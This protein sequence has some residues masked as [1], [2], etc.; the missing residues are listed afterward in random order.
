MHCRN[1][2][3]TLVGIYCHSCGQ[4]AADLGRPFY[5]LVQEVLQETLEVDGRVSRTLSALVLKPGRLTLGYL[6]GQR[7]LYTPPLRLYLVVSVLFFLFVGWV[8]RQEFFFEIQPETQSTAQVLTEQLPQLMFVYLPVFALL[9]KVLF[10]QRYY[11]D[12]LIHALHLHT[13]AYLAL[14]IILPFERAADES[15]LLLMLQ[16]AVF[17]YMAWYL[18]TSLQQVYGV[19]KLAAS[20]QTLALFSAYSAI[21]ASSLEFVSHLSA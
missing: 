2:K 4:K 16:L 21:L 6:G 19:G 5:H 18:F 17:T 20:I 1:C 14:V 10:R 8:I 13:A 3:T 11:F 15:R 7:Q 12:H 9:L